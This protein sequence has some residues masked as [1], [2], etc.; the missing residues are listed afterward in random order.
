MDQSEFDGLL[1]KWEGNYKKG[2]LTFW[3]LLILFKHEAYAFEMSEQVTALSKGTIS[4]DENSIYRAM[5]RFEDMGL[6][7][8]D[9]RDSDIGPRR[10]YYRLS[11]LGLRLLAEFTRRNILLFKEDGVAQHIDALLAAGH[12]MEGNNDGGSID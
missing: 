10:R 9:W 3:L 8:S 6:V 12:S 7:E 11:E 2:L 1:E 5:N 4:A